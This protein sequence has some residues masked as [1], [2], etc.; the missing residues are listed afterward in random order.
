MLA[1]AAAKGLDVNFLRIL[2]IS[3]RSPSEGS[4]PDQGGDNAQTAGI[5]HGA[6]ELCT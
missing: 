5:G 4:R 1:A 6:C 3:W 2:R